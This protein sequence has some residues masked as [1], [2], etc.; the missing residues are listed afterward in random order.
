MGKWMSA[1]V[2]AVAL[3]GCGGEPVQGQVYEGPGGQAMLIGTPM[4]RERRL[5]PKIVEAPPPAKP[6]ESVRAELEVVVPGASEGR[7]LHVMLGSLGCGIFV[8]ATGSAVVRNGR[9]HIQLNRALM[10]DSSRTVFISLDGNADGACTGADT[11]WSAT[12]D[13]AQND[14][15]VSLDLEELEGGPSWMCFGAFGF[16]G[17]EEEG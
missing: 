13:T 4:V 5:L 12:L 6:R 11:M 8:E 14:V 3:V 10:A 17:G 1:V 2:A 15:S 7:R 16:G 9:V